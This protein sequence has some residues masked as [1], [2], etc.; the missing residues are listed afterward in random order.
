[1]PYLISVIIPTYNCEKYI[2]ECLD[3][4]VN[5]T[6]GINNIEVI[7][8]DDA[9]TDNT[10]EIA[11]EYESQYPSFKVLRHDTNKG[12]GPGRNTGLEH[13]TTD[14]VTYMDGDDYISSNAYERALERFEQDKEVD[15]VIYKWE[16]FDEKGLWNKK[17][18]SK[19]LLREDK[20]I[21]NIKDYPE[22]I[23]ANYAYI[24]VY[25]KRLFKYLKFPPRTYQDVCPSARVMINAKK[26]YVAGDITVYYRQYH[27]SASKDVS[28]QNYLN[29]LIAS[30]QVIDL[31]DKYPEFYDLLSF[32]ALKI[33]YWPINHI[34]NSPY[35]TLDS[36]ECVYK[37]LKD[38]P[39]YFSPE[40]I[41]K[42]QYNF[43]NYLQASPEA[44]WDIEKLD[45]CEYLIKHRYQKDI[46]NLKQDIHL[47]NQEIINL[48]HELNLKDKEIRYLKKEN[49]KKDK[50]SKEVLNS[51]SWKITKPLRKIKRMINKF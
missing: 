28:C 29:L 6:L 4:I 50:K 16:E 5:Q 1:M 24:K 22:I 3:S 32:L 10:Y 25:H 42:Y 39:Q 35:F 2:R 36:G 51:N 11:K 23:F 18:I 38:Y 41:D 7:V 40:I 17:E 49:L 37:K 15:L 19:E 33:A 48:K 46:K 13:V 26:I 34:C 27:F 47:K 44:M 14:Y 30:K 12:C 43:P 31:R 9:S 20:I 8:V 45:Y 21:T